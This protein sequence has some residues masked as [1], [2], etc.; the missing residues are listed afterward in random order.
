ML[1]STRTDYSSKVYDFIDYPF[2]T[3]EALM[4]QY[5]VLLSTLDCPISQSDT[6]QRLNLAALIEKVIKLGV[7]FQASAW[8]F[9]CI[10]RWDICISELLERIISIRI[11]PT[12]RRKE[13]TS[14]GGVVAVTKRYKYG[15]TRIYASG[16]PSFQPRIA[17]LRPHN[18]FIPIYLITVGQN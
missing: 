14:E 5:R 6:R 9:R 4:I 18:L 10:I 8:R 11:I 13:R 16:A 12:S 3:S 7:I 1:V 2:Y 17:F 15:T